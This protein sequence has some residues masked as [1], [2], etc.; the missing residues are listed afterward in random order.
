MYLQVSP[1]KGV[2]RFGVKRKLAPHYIGP[3]PIIARCG[4]VAYKLELPTKHAEV[5]DIFLVLQLK[6]CLKPPVDKILDDVEHLQPDLTYSEHLVRILDK[7]ERITR[8]RK[9]KFFKVQWSNHSEKEATWESKEFLRTHY[10]EFLL[11]TI[12]T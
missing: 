5:H 4:Q 6:K 9:L 8:R 10:P 11:E 2:P 7:K 12:G 3:Y 1:T